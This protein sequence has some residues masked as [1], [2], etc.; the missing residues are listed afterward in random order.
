MKVHCVLTNYGNV[1]VRFLTIPIKYFILPV[2]VILQ[3]F[4]MNMH[5][6]SVFCQMFF[7]IVIIIVCFIIL[8]FCTKYITAKKLGCFKLKTSRRCLSFNEQC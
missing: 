3:C 1:V 7:M 8:Y 5:L 4:Y 2:Q 6:S